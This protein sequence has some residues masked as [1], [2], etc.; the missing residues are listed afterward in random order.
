MLVYHGF[1]GEVV[2]RTG[3]LCVLSKY[4]LFIGGHILSAM[5]MVC[6]LYMDCL[7]VCVLYV[8]CLMVC[9][10]TVYCFSVCVVNSLKITAI[11]R[12]RFHQLVCVHYL[13][14]FICNNLSKLH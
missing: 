2:V 7:M 10:M 11:G 9:G 3:F 8:G 12:L 6:V 13:A 14:Y 4:F 1:D 5:Y